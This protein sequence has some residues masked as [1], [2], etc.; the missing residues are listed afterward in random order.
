MKMFYNSLSI[1]L[2]F[3]CAV[4]LL[5]TACTPKMDA[6]KPGSH[7][8]PTRPNAPP[9]VI[10]LPDGIEVTSLA[11]DGDH[12]YATA[13]S[14]DQVYRFDISDLSNLAR[15]ASA[16]PYVK[17]PGAN[18]I[19]SG[20]KN[21]L[22]IGSS[23]GAATGHRS[24]DQVIYLTQATEYWHSRFTNNPAQKLFVAPRGN[25][26]ALSVYDG[27]LYYA[28]QG[29]LEGMTVLLEDRLLQSLG[30]ISNLLPSGFEFL[31][32]ILVGNADFGSMD[33][34]DIL[35][36]A[37]QFHP[38]IDLAPIINDP[39]DYVG[40]ALADLNF[41]KFI[42]PGFDGTKVE[43]FNIVLRLDEL[44]DPLGSWAVTLAY[45]ANGFDYNLRIALPADLLFNSLSLEAKWGLNLATLWYSTPLEI[46]R[47]DAI[48]LLSDAM[49]GPGGLQDV[50]VEAVA[51]AIGNLDGTLGDI[52]EYIYRNMSSIIAYSLMDNDNINEMLKDYLTPDGKLSLNGNY[53]DQPGQKPPRPYVW[54]Y[55]ISL[56][57]DE[58]RTLNEKLAL[59]LH[60]LEFKD[61]N[62]VVFSLLDD[63]SKFDKFL[64][65]LNSGNLLDQIK[66]V[67]D[68]LEIDVIESVIDNPQI[69][70][71]LRFVETI[72]NVTGFDGT[73]KVA[74]DE[75]LELM[76][77]FSI[78]IDFPVLLDCW[79]G[80]PDWAYLPG[81]HVGVIAPHELLGGI[82]GQIDQFVEDLGG[83][84]SSVAGWITS[85]IPRVN[86]AQN[87]SWWYGGGDPTG[88]A[89]GVDATLGNTAAW[90]VDGGVLYSRR[91][92]M[93][94]RGYGGTIKR[95]DYPYS[96][97]Y[98]APDSPWTQ[99]PADRGRWSLVM[100]SS[101]TGQSPTNITGEN[102]RL[103]SNCYGVIYDQKN[104][105]V[106]V[107]CNDGYA[108]PGSPLSN[109]GRIVSVNYNRWAPFSSVTYPGFYPPPPRI[110]VP[111]QAISG[112]NAG[113]NVYEY[114]PADG[115]LNNPKGM[116]IKDDY[117]F[118]ADG[119]RIVVYYMGPTQ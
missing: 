7:N 18:A 107:S 118:I 61:D 41:T 85:K 65:A 33:L 56:Y 90:V 15:T 3:L 70:A 13:P 5:I 22:F 94:G 116:A 108:A 16:V 27:N 84:W 97:E 42:V 57:F 23:G 59:T 112:A 79:M 96:T 117:F 53:K 109:K 64:A 40:L 45:I 75:L 114:I 115:T 39:T 113:F 28:A 77:A 10:A 30:A 110:P 12:L 35:L 66:G 100:G 119:N 91:I 8:D 9:Q 29:S 93:G 32:D 80:L 63:R 72:A 102:L 31:L 76:L 82:Y 21:T 98:P 103:L 52:T 101:A 73:L 1:K 111:P 14:E 36:L 54:E 50:I 83:L 6:P 43:R 49:G 48:A 86:S 25:F 58:D 11:I 92:D 44:L 71:Y 55:P 105:R 106:L 81:T 17:V 60:L 95:D 34:G 104:G 26:N 24:D 2:F 67:V 37:N 4:A 20:E 69:I 38:N 51:G 87:Q 68:A 89:F 74:L 88:I 99:D 46:D 47:A 19:T 78:T 62:G